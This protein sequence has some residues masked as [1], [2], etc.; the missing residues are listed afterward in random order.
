MQ[1]PIRVNRAPVLTLWAAIVA[2]RLGHAPRTALSLASALAGTAARARV[3]RPGRAEERGLAVGAGRPEAPPPRRAVMLLGRE[4]PVT[5]IA[6][7]LLAAEPDG[8]PAGP[9]PVATY[10]ARAFGDRLPEARAAMTALAD[11]LAPA[12]LNRVGQ[13]L[14][15]AFRPEMPAG[16]GGGGARAVLDLD[17]IRDAC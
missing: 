4:I 6:G 11:R 8:Q 5:D 15:E 9:A 10:L 7:E 1:P 16:A 3:L 14:Y 2:E 17:R 13:R 12:D